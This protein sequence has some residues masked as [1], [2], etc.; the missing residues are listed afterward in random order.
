M[1]N[2][3]SVRQRPGAL[4]A[5]GLLAGL[6]LLL[7][8]WFI[9]EMRG[10]PFST[11][12]PQM[13]DAWYYHRWALEIARHDFW[14]SDVFFLR[15]LYP[16]LLAGIYSL[17]GVSVIAVQLIQ[18]AMAAVSALLLFAI[19]NQ[20]FG[21][22]AAILAS[23]GFAL[24]GVLVFYTGTLLYVEITIL[25]T[26]LTVWLLLI[27]NRQ[28]WLWLAAGVAFGLSVICRPELIVIVP[29]LGL[30]LVWRRSGWRLPLLAAAGAGLVIAAVP[31]RNYIVARDPVLFTAHSGINF[32]YGNNPAADGAWQPAPELHPTAGFSHDALKETARTINGRRQS[33]SAA[34]SYWFNRGLRFIAGSPL[35]WLRLEARK[36]LLFVA[37]YEIPNNY[38]P[39]TARRSSV[40]LRVAFLSFGMILALAVPGMWWAWRSRQRILPIYL[41]VLAYVA[42]SLM[43]YVLSRLRAPVIPFLLVFAGFALDR[44]I[45]EL[46]ARRLGRSWPGI[47]AAAAVLTASRLV[48]VKQNTYRSQAHTQAANILLQQRQLRPALA[49]LERA[50]TADP[51]NASARYTLIVALAS[52]GRAAEAEEHYRRLVELSH[53]SPV[54]A[55]LVSLATARLAISRR[56]F[57]TASRLYHQ[58]LAQNPNDAE[59]WY[60]L[61]L[62]AISTDSLPAARA[63][64]Q[65]AVTLD[66]L[67]S[68]ARTALAAVEA[69]LPR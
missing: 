39:E 33:W 1:P 60:L 38:Y 13:V 23:A 45:T 16:Y 58:A 61:G 32:Y 11:I 6:T 51:A 26:L 17:F 56:D 55:P 35:A 65:R 34:S 66:P 27:A 41:Y 36:L 24:C 48:P 22:R 69:R 64:L 25:L 18:A 21:R 20:L 40:A 63:Y 53:S 68:E 4:P 7:R 5:A 3:R 19:T 30:W 28:R 49:E 37:D 67:H 43:F 47:A 8:L 62:V 12:S 54:V 9:L 14:G 57:A 31:L 42:S 50:V 59:V 46:R 44:F 52:A 2:V 29:G 15:P 10:T